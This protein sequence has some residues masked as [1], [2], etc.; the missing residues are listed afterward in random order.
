MP[1]DKLQLN[2]V[3]SP[4]WMVIEG[5]YNPLLP[6]IT[7]STIKVP[8]RTGVI[9]QGTEL[10]Q[11]VIEVT[12]GIIGTT[13]DN[14]D[15]R[16]R[17]FT[18][19]LFYPDPKKFVLPHNDKYYLAQ[20]VDTD[21][22]QT[23][24]FGRG[25]IKFLCTDPAAY[26]QEETTVDITS[27]PTAIINN[28]NMDAHPLIDVTFSQDS[29]EF[30]IITEDQYLYFGQPAPVDNTTPVPVKTSVFRDYCSSTAGWTAG[31]GVDNGT[32]TGSITSD[33]NYFIQA[34]GDYGSG[35]AWH[36]GALVHTLGRQVQNFAVEYFI[37]FK[38]TAANQLGRMEIYL[39]DINN[40]VIGK[41]AVVDPSATSEMGRVECRVGTETGGKYLVRSEVG[42][43]FY[44]NFY[45]RL[46]LQR[47]GQKYY[48]QVGKLT[49]PG[50]QY[51]GRYN[52][53]WYDT[54]NQFQ[55]PLAGIQIHIG[56]FG[57]NP[58]NPR[59]RIN[60]IR[61]WDETNIVDGEVPIIFQ[62]GDRLVIDS[63]TGQS[64]LNDDP[65]P[66]NFGSDYIHFKPGTTNLTYTPPIIESG[67]ITYREKWLR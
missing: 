4:E 10:G 17:E 63:K 48:F 40:T 2:D 14:L 39:L 50:Y 16:E 54:A 1:H 24:V 61:V 34:G 6:D 46:F 15:D 3:E 26:S 62:A 37:E 55:T 64:F 8:G 45:G 29:T 18:S 13:K 67:S 49:V 60:E 22:K 41:L 59:M 19:W 33:G 23:L 57:T 5:I 35:S 12:V 38:P 47:I 56:A 51:F 66:I 21:V 43:G 36:G 32:I 52:Y 42:R 11:R 7:V 65:I 28:G 25:V 30:G 58:A 44:S 27:T 53:T 31:I 20:V 9:N